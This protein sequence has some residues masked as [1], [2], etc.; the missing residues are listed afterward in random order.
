MSPIK[1]L[2]LTYQALNEQGTFSAGD[3]ISGTVSFILI[4]DTKVK[5]VA[6]KAK[7]DAHVHWTEGTGDDKKTYTAH[8]RYFKEKKYCVP[9]KDSGTVLSKGPHQFQFSFRIPQ[10]DIPSS[11]MGS[12][13][14]IVYLLEA[15]VSR[16]WR[17]P[18]SIQKELRFVSKSFPHIGQALCPQSGSVSKEVGTFSKGQ[19]NLSATVN[20][21][22]CYPGDTLSAFA[23]I[24][25]NSSKD[26]A[27]KFNLLQKTVYRAGGNTNVVEKSLFKSVGDIIRPNTEATA[28]CQV[29]IPDDTIYTVHNCE[30][31]SVE[32]YLK[33]YVDISFSFDPEVVF[34]LVLVP[35]S[36]LAFYAAEPM[37]PY[38]PAAVGGQS[39]SD[40]PPPAFPMG[41]NPV[42]IAAGACQYPPH[43]TQQ[44]NMA[45]GYNNQWPQQT[46]PYGFPPAAFPPAA[47]P[48]S[49]VQPAVPTAPTAPTAPPQFP[50]GENPPPYMALFPPAHDFLGRSGPD[51]K[52]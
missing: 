51:Q 42:P 25:N 39:H 48:Q 8:R 1:D 45:S 16:S 31:I 4:K 19:V 11:F 17:F 46:T 7:G 35:S 26:V 10:E 23:N 36:V 6:V 15:S 27:S 29:K 43:P 34:P 33:A 12:S 3:T 22:A 50:Q 30:I 37:G 49:S 28:S 47:Y 32:Y 52:S 5:S 13:G 18:S 44:V 14:R 24:S 41:P 9:E 20:K 21:K 38:Q 2:N 40:F